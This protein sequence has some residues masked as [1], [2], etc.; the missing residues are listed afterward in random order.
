MTYHN[1]PGHC[2]PPVKRTHSAIAFCCLASMARG[3]G[4]L[5]ISASS[6]GADPGTAYSDAIAVPPHAVPAGRQ[7]LPVHPSDP[8]DGTLARFMGH[9]RAVDQLYE[10]LMR[11]SECLLGLRS[12]SIGGGC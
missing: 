6:F 9:A 1:A 8:P 10:D 2:V 4:S 7:R 12:T 11:S 5:A 3:A